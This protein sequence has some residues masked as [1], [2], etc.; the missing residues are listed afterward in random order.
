MLGMLLGFILI[1]LTVALS[2]SIYFRAIKELYS[3]DMFTTF[4]GF[5]IIVYVFI[6]SVYISTAFSMGSM[7][8]GNLLPTFRV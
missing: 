3:T 5:L 4:I 6:I 2:L 8:F 7:L 1:A